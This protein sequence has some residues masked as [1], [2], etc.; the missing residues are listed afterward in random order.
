M[1]AVPS[2]LSVL[3]STSPLEPY[4][5]ALLFTIVAPVA[6]SRRLISSLSAVTPFMMFNSLVEAV[7]P[8]N[9]LSSVLS[10]VKPL[11]A[12]RLEAEAVT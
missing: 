6:P 3:M 11:N 8:S 10:A 4:T 2:I 1:I 12:L 5:T 9:T 7:I